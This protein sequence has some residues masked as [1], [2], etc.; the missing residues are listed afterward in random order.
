GEVA[1][2]AAVSTNDI[3]DTVLA[4]LDAA[5]VSATAGAITV[6]ATSSSNI[7]NV[8]VG[9]AGSGN[10]AVSGS[11]S[12]N[13]IANTTDAHVIDNSV[14]TASGAVGVTATDT[15]T[16]QILAGGFAGATTVAASVANATNDIA[17]TVTGYVDKSK[18]TS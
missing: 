5:T 2:G 11:V 16:M 12:Y 3:S 14:A 4:Y 17:N 9:G 13:R 1:A 6:S 7:F 18:V 10:V 8:T 15:S